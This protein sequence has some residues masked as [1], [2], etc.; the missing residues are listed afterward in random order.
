MRTQLAL[1]ETSASARR[2]SITTVQPTNLPQSPMLTNFRRRRPPG[3]NG[4]CTWLMHPT[5]GSSASLRILV[6]ARPH[7]WNTRGTTL[8]F[9]KTGTTTDCNCS[10]PPAA[11]GPATVPARLIITCTDRQDRA[12]QVAEVR[13]TQ[14]QPMLGKYSWLA[15]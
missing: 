7:S 5:S 6:A 1:L 11:R 9:G 3:N 4:T 14:R 15:P 12:N 2:L 8:S 13:A 10:R